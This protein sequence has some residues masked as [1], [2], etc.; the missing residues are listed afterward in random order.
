MLLTT[1]FFL[2]LTQSHRFP[3][4]LRH[5]NTQRY[6]EVKGELL[7]FFSVSLSPLQQRYIL[8]RWFWYMQATNWEKI[9]VKHHRA[10]CLEILIMCGVAGSNRLQLCYHIQAFLR[11]NFSVPTEILFTVVHRIFDNAICFKYIRNK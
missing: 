6:N 1:C 2:L 7:Y 3:L 11:A 10:I 8:R 4:R 9:T 5:K